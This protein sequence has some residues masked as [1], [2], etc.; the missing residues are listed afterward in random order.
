[1]VVKLGYNADTGSVSFEAITSAMRASGGT[2]HLIMI[3][4][5]G[6]FLRTGDYD[7]IRKY[8]AAVPN[9]K[10]IIRL[11]S[12]LEGQWSL[13]PK[14]SEYE[15]EWRKAKANLGALT[16]RLVFDAP[17]N[18]PNLAGDNPTEAKKFVD[19]C[20]AL[21]Q[22]A[23]RAGV[24]IAVGCFSVGTPHESLI[25]TVY[26]PLWRVLDELEQGISVHCYG[27]AIPEL[28][29]IISLDVVL[30][31]LRSRASVRGNK[32]PINHWGW[33]IARP[34]RIIQAYQELGLGIPEIYVT[35]G[36]VDNVFNSS[37]SDIKEAWKAEYASPAYPDP[38]GIQSWEKWL[39]K[40][41][42][43]DGFDFGQCLNFLHRHARKN[44]FWHSA[45]KAVCLFALNKQWGYGYNGS[46]DG[47]NKEAGSNYDHPAFDR[48]RNDYLPAIN[49]EI[50]EDTP[51]PEIT[52]IP[53]RIKS[54]STSTLI[55]NK[56]QG[57]IIGKIGAD[58]KIGKIAGNYEAAKLLPLNNAEAW[59]KV[60]IEGVSGYSAA[61]YLDV[62]KIIETPP[63]APEK[64]YVLDLGHG[65]V[66]LLNDA[67]KLKL[68]R[69]IQSLD[70][71]LD[72]MP[73]KE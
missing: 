56:A 48:F 22:A 27:A 36:I 44:I 5:G 57:D 41:F 35:E 7:T 3:D 67:E 28:G 72:E 46:P 49:A 25:K 54:N 21:A 37:N 45:F 61:F 17:S 26:A 71:L 62:E 33:L 73:L 24:K 4:N 32:W 47:T 66:I 9:C 16:N 11:Y 42:E 63:P 55:R 69:I 19:H 52:M 58:Y 31:P 18:E 38:R 60:E 39:L 59:V 53:A 8:C 1:M 40:V 15:L 50:Y 2:A 43:S 30:D 29:E 64:Q 13:Y 23:N 68:K 12:K 70:L 20:I 10:F 34:Y 14:A 6:F 65:T 51:M